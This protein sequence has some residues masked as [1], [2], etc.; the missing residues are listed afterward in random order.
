MLVLGGAGHL[1]GALLGTVLFQV[2]EHVVSAENPFHWLTLVGLLLIAIVVFAP[3][4]LVSPA[5]KLWDRASQK[6]SPR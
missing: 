5:Q 6:R 2:F 1:Y 4:G 3:K